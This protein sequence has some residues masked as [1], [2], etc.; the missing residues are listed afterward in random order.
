MN[1]ILSVEA[2]NVSYGKHRVLEN[3]SFTLDR[4]DYV[5]IV[6]P[7]GS[8]KP[9][10]FKPCWVYMNQTREKFILEMA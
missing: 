5:G 9:L 7:N 2:L 3:I 10:W 1:N 6:G 4:G 8:G